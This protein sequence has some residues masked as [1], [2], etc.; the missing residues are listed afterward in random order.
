[1]H[2][3]NHFYLLN[4]QAICLQGWRRLSTNRLAL[5]PSLQHDMS[6]LPHFTTAQIS[7]SALQ[8]ECKEILCSATGDSRAIFELGQSMT[9]GSKV[10]WVIYWLLWQTKNSLTQERATGSRCSHRLTDDAVGQSGGERPGDDCERVF[11]DPVRNL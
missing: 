5:L 10:N 3:I 4:N 1:M 8:E 11:W 6:V 9:D 7:S 2:S